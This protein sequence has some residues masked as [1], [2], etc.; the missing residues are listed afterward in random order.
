MKLQAN[1]ELCQGYAN[2]VMAAPDWFDL[3]DSSLVVI[4]DDPVPARDLPDVDEAIRSCPVD[5]IW[6][7]RA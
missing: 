7:Q 2:C 4:S 3:D 5:A 1:Q 6:L